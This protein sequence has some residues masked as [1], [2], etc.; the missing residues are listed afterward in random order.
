MS[1]I[2]QRIRRQLYL[3]GNK[4]S[5]ISLYSCLLFSMASATLSAGC[6]AIKFQSQTC[7]DLSPIWKGIKRNSRWGRES[8]MMNLYDCINKVNSLE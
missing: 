4:L 3:W 2:F 5:T 1:Y 6:I 7:I 8:R